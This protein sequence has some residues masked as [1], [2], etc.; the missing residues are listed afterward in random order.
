MSLSD[1]NGMISY[2]TVMAWYPIEKVTGD[3]SENQIGL[4]SI[5][6]YESWKMWHPWDVLVCV[7]AGVFNWN[8]D[9]K[10]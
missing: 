10:M 5:K 1:S 8:F 6:K 2:W 7:C 3:R 9:S 4:G